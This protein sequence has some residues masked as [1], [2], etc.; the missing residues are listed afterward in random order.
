MSASR[1]TAIH[2]SVS[3]QTFDA[4][5]KYFVSYFES[6]ET[7]DK[8]IKLVLMFYST[9]G[10]GVWWGSIPVHCHFLKTDVYIKKKV[11]I[12]FLLDDITQNGV[13]GED[14]S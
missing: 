6:W 9:K 14:S 12:I 5:N 13:E 4:I 11:F 2:Q 1:V 7:F 3:A 8:A 10:G